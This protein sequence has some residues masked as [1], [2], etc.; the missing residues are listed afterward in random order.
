MTGPLKSAVVILLLSAAVLA[1][2]AC[3]LRTTAA[4]RPSTSRVSGS[5]YW[6]RF[7]SGSLIRTSAPF[8]EKVPFLPWTVQSRAAGLLEIGSTLYIASNGWGIIALPHPS[9]PPAKIILVADPRLF[10]GRTVNGIYDERGNL[11]VDVYRNTL[12]TTPTPEMGPLNAVMFDTMTSR[13]EPIVLPSG[14]EGWEAVD[15]VHTSADLWVIAWKRTLSDR[16][17]FKYSAYSP[18]TAKESPVSRR[19]YLNA[20]GYD[21]LASAPPGLRSIAAAIAAANIADT[22]VD[23]HVR[24]AG[25][26]RILRFRLGSSERLAAGDANLVSVPVVAT[27]REYY[28]LTEQ[29]DILSAQTREA[30]PAPGPMK[31]LRVHALPSLPPG[32]VYTDLW[33]D[34]A[35]VVVSWEEQRFTEV[36]AAGLYLAPLAP[37]IPVVQRSTPAPARKP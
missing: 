14:R 11:L 19:E 22:V 1:I 28:A 2:A 5:G 18:A 10:F 34:G 27:S 15:V 32:Y 20:Y 37:G 36:G 4:A 7:E 24:K 17:Q 6:Y 26:S 13:L 23:L 25:V 35:T 30:R 21:P 31:R 33:T 9:F 29:G 3:S 16:V 12:F 8:A